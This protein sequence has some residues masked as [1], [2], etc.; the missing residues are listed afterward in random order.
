MWSMQS[1]VRL[2]S[3]WFSTLEAR[4]FSAGQQA[5]ERSDYAAAAVEFLPLAERGNAIA[6]FNLGMMCHDGHGVPQDDT[7]SA[8]W[9]HL[10]AE[11]GI[12]GGAIID[13]KAPRKR[14]FVA[15]QK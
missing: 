2:L 4:C 7:E 5:Y 10:A 13:H 12:N 8:R 15:V 6:Q 11:Q 9:L 14:R 1:V 3:R